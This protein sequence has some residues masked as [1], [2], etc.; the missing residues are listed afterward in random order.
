MFFHSSS[1]YRLIL[2]CSVKGVDVITFLLFV[3]IKSEIVAIFF[4]FSLSFKHFHI[5]TKLSHP[6]LHG[7]RM[8]II[9]STYELGFIT[10]SFITTISLIDMNFSL[11]ALYLHLQLGIG[12][13]PEVTLNANCWTY[14]YKMCRCTMQ[15]KE[16]L[17]IHSKVLNPKSHTDQEESDQAKT[18]QSTRMHW[19]SLKRHA[20]ECGFLK[21]A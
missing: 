5:F 7:S 6:F 8:A 10:T 11:S 18:N 17:M 3:D 21:A 19:R 1:K 2:S 9:S 20:C 13:K 12:G 15:N 4:C 16:G 14:S